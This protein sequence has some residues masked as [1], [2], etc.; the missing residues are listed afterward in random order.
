M[1]EREQNKKVKIDYDKAKV[2]RES[3]DSFA[4]KVKE[5]YEI[6]QD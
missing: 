1:A 4:N 5:K 6:R 3:E 2:E